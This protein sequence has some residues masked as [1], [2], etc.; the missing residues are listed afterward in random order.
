MNSVIKEFV[1]A[2]EYCRVLERVAL[3]AATECQHAALRQE[4]Q[5]A[6]EELDRRTIAITGI[7]FAEGKQPN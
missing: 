6:Y 5:W 4:L 2:H 7:R 1:R 3:S